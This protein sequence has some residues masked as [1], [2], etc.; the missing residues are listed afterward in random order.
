MPPIVTF[1]GRHNCGKTTLA[2]QVVRRLKERGYSIAVIKST[3]ET[4]LVLDQA[5]TDTFRYRQA[6]ADAV[7]LI[8]PDQM[9]MKTINPGKRLTTLAHRYFPDVDLVIGEGFK[10][11]VQVAKIEVSRNDNEGE[12]LR[13]QV[14]GVIAIATNRRIA[15]D[16]IFRLDESGE[17]AD[18]IEKRFL[19][20]NLSKKDQAVLLVNGNKVVMKEFVQEILANTITGFVKSLKTTQ[21]AREIELRIRIPSKNTGH[22]KK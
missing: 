8:A 14:N 7:T 12:L 1:I 5:G 15:G 4:G 17:L 13:D 9:V 20:D 21:G 2:T 16:Y 22:E 10:E 11:A 19:G 3:K 18:F 6:G